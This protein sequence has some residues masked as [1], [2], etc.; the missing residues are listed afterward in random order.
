MTKNQI[1]DFGL[2]YTEEKGGDF[3]NASP[4]IYKIG[5]PVFDQTKVH[6]S[7]TGTF[8]VGEAPIV[9]AP[10]GA[11]ER[12][13]LAIFLRDPTASLENYGALHALFA[14]HGCSPS[15]MAL[16]SFNDLMAQANRLL[17]EAGHEAWV[18]VRR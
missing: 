17:S 3:E 8:V 1:G 11:S 16:T 7:E 13:A 5:V 15:G 10:D 18:V 4:G 2:G 12:A 14:R 6:T 9:E